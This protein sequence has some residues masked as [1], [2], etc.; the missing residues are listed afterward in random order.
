MQIHNSV[1]LIL[2]LQSDS[3]IALVPVVLFALAYTFAFFRGS[4][5][6]STIRHCITHLPLAAAAAC[7]RMYLFQLSLLSYSTGN[8]C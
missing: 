6:C 7:G 1:L 2:L 3:A 5:K 8:G 4:S